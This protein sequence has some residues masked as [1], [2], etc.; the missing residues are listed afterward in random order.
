MRNKCKLM[1]VSLLLPVWCTS[2][3]GAEKG[4]SEHDLLVL[5]DGGVYNA[6]IVQLVRDR[7]V[8]FAPT[9]NELDK[10][11]DAGADRTLLNA[12]ERA[13]QVTAPS[14]PQR[15][16]QQSSEGRMNVAHARQ[17]TPR[18]A[19][20]LTERQSS[21]GRLNVAQ[22][23]QIDGHRDLANDCKGGSMYSAHDIVG[24]PQACIMGS[25][26]MRGTVSTA[27]IGA[28]SVGW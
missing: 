25:L 15:T 26:T 21:E 11:R 4:L 17:V 12:I 16:E 6:R 9:T 18:S 5:L 24:D 19:P 14:V 28:V 3:L 22:S 27:V 10:L 2:A 7:G 23:T 1:L 20:Q 13:R 8:S